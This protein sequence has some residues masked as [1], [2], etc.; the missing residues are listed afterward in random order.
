[1]AYWK[2]KRAHVE[3]KD[4]HATKFDDRLILI[5]KG[6]DLEATLTEDVHKVLC[7]DGRIIFVSQ[8]QLPSL[9]F[10]LAASIHDRKCDFFQRNSSPSFT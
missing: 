8:A 4:A 1:M 5:L 7:E 9:L 3:D 10:F 2:I 6:S